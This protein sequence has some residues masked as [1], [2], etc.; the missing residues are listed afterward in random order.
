MESSDAI[1][2]RANENDIDHV[3]KII[4]NY[5]GN[6]TL[7]L[8]PP[9]Y[10]EVWARISNSD[11]RTGIWVME[12]EGNVIGYG[13]IKK[14][15]PK[16][17]YRYTGET[18]V[19]LLPFFQN[20][21]LGTKLKEFIVEKSRALGYH[22]LIAKIFAK[23]QVSIHYNKNMGYRIVGYLQEAGKVNGS[24]IEICIMQLIL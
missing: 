14:F 17:G 6:A 16:E 18:S 1:I 2:R 8:N 13:E 11:P 9:T 5:L 24:W 23:N 19:F 12:L 20:R 22:S 3:I 10:G 7:A 4:T 15:S 21:G